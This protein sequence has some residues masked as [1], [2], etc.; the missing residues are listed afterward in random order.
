MNLELHEIDENLK[1]LAK[2]IEELEQKARGHLLIEKLLQDQER[3]ID[4]VNHF[5][6]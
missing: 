3:L 1:V 5:F 2:D 6:Y 4:K